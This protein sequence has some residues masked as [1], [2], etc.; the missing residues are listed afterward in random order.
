MR[1][2][3]NEILLNVVAVSVYCTN[4]VHVVEKIAEV[5]VDEIHVVNNMLREST[6][7]SFRVEDCKKER[8][9]KDSGK[10]TQE[11]VVCDVVTMDNVATL[12]KTI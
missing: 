11:I 10:K 3:K 5:S 4:K 6:K 2:K 12:S 1:K 8:T 9:V 7:E